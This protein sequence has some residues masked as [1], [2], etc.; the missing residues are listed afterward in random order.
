LLSLLEASADLFAEVTQPRLCHEDLHG[1]NVLFRQEN[2]HWQLATILDF[3][4][5]WA[6]HHEIDLAKLEFWTDMTGNGFWDAYNQLMD[7]DTSYQQ[8]RPIYQLLWCLEYA[9]NTPKHL[10]DTRQLCEMLNFPLIERFEKPP[11]YE[12]DNNTWTTTDAG[13]T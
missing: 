7:V 2:G 6:G 9:S 8:R 12:S 10:A 11:A 4:K 13:R 1:H 5:A 3:D